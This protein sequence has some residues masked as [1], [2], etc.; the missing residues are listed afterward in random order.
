MKITLSNDFHNSSVVLDVP[1]LS[2]IWNETE[3]QTITKRQAA[4]ARRALCGISGC[5]CGGG[6]FGQ[7][8]RQVTNGKRLRLPPW[9][10]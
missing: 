3:V 5:T 9:A 10:D 6:A 4:K 7:R 1:A 2:R 8:G